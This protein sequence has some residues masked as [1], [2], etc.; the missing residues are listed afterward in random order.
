VGELEDTYAYIDSSLSWTTSWPAASNEVKAAFAKAML[1]KQYGRDPLHTSWVWFLDGWNANTPS[2]L[3]GYRERLR[4][5][6]AKLAFK[7]DYPGGAVENL[8]YLSD[9]VE[10]IESGELE[11]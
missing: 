7:I 2:P 10:A 1:G 8:V 9:L 6:M 4:N 11:K 3:A 5:H